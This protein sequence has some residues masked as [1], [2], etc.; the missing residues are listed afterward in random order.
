MTHYDLLII[1]TGSGNTILR[2]SYRD[3]SIAI[4]ERW[5]FGG[6]CANVGCIPTKMYV[7]TA[8]VADTPR[9]SS[10]LGV[11]LT[12][13]AVDWPA[14]RERI[15]GRLDPLEASGRAYRE[16]AE[17]VTV[18][19]A[20]VR[21]TGPH[22]FRT[23]AGEEFTADR[24]VLAAG[25]SPIIPEL[26]GL[27]PSDVSTPGH[28]TPLHTSDTIMRLETLPSA[29][30]IL[31]GG[32]VA[33]EMAHVFSSLGVEVT[34]VL[35]GG[36]MLRV[37]DE[38]ISR[39]FTAAAGRRWRLVTDARIA[40][41][42]VGETSVSL[43]LGG[44]VLGAD[45]LLLATGRRPATTGLGLETSNIDVHDDGRVAVDEYQRVLSAG[46]PMPGIYALGDISSPYLLK[47]VANLEAKV[48]SDN[49]IADVRSGTVGGAEEATLRRTSHEAVPSAV[50][51]APQVA[52]VGLT[53]EQARATGRRITVKIQEYADVAYGW[54][55]EDTVSCAKLI[56]DADSRQLLGAHIIGP[57]AS[58]LLQP[59][60]TAMS[61]GIPMD[62]FASGQYWPHPA[63]TEVVENAVLG[64]TFD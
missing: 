21:F 57:E 24:V 47:H 45:V 11:D 34:I 23:D 49:V 10:R 60:V 52:S 26:P 63:L 55:L 39:R 32:F 2:G 12:R 46:R 25:A 28:H 48:V 1:G 22:S 3:L 62:S 54:A 7:H 19:P 16:R 53:E 44:E 30:I 6:T 5:H 33:A 17:N 41:V 4:A 9:D 8:D 56:A 42:S 14:I 29:M 61:F 35:R 31:G 13:T 20:T 37:E 59:L 18:Y 36:A 40:G 58:I 27:D 50:F 43:D 38:E 51:S 15:F 64:L